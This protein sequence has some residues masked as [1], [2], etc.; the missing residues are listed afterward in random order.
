MVIESV[1]IVL[2][3]DVGVTSLR[4]LRGSASSLVGE[5][6]H[7]F[8]SSGKQ[9]GSISY[10]SPKI[11]KPDNLIVCKEPTTLPVFLCRNTG[12]RCEHLSTRGH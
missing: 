9:V 8:K 5:W 4:L 1:V 3:G 7:S 6:H 12:S 10:G 2:A 11:E